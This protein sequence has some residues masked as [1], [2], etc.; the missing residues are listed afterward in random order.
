MLE[1]SYYTGAQTHK[2]L[3]PAY[4]LFCSH[5]QAPWSIETFANGLQNDLSSMLIINHKLA[6][7]IIVTNVLDEAEI[8]DICIAYEFRQK[9]LASQLIQSLI[10]MAI[11]QNI[12]RIFLEV[13]ENNES[14]QKLYRKSGF[15]EVGRRKNY[16]QESGYG[17][18]ALV[19]KKEIRP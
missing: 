17:I 16:Y 1:Y 2:L 12:Q 15:L 5:R 3:A 4:A 11:T 13:A 19:L 7:Y 14:A 8:E 18:D 6:G 9:G 10:D